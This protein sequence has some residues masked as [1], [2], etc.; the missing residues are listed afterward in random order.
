[1]PISAITTPASIDVAKSE[2]ADP[3]IEVLARPDLSTQWFDTVRFSTRREEPND[4]GLGFLSFFNTIPGEDDQ[5]RYEFARVVT[6]P[7]TLKL[8]VNL[9]CKQLDYYPEKE[10]A[11]NP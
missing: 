3:K 8:M 9:I 10:E 2:K 6:T 5:R 7:K 11:S 4:G 1:L